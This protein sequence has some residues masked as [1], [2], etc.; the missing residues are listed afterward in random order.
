[1]TKSGK[2]TVPYKYV[3]PSCSHADTVYFADASRDGD[4]DSVVC[5]ECGSDVTIALAAVTAANGPGHTL[6]F[7]TTGKGKTV[8]AMAMQTPDNAT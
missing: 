4:S 8:F 3:C 7:G 5:C 1:M 6:V 2:F